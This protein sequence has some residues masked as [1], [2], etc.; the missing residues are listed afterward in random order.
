MPATLSEA[1]RARLRELRYFD[2]HMTAVAAIR[3]VGAQRW[4]DAHFLRRLEA[5]KEYLGL[6]R[7]DS[8]DGFVR[9]FDILLPAEGFAPVA[10]DDLFDAATQQKIRKVSR[11]IPADRLSAAEME[12]FGRHIV[13]DHPWFVELQQQLAPR[14]SALAGRE[15]ECGYNFLSLY[16]GGGKCDPHMDSPLAMYTL[17]YCIEQSEDWPIWFSKVC[18]W[19]SA[20]A[21]RSWDAQA[22][23]ADPALAFRAYRL[24]PGKALLFNGSSQWHYRDALAA[25][26]FCSLLFFHYFPKGAAKLV[27][28]VLWSQHFDIPELEPLCDLFREEFAEAG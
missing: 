5:A 2:L 24:Q 4:Y 10:I 6:V 3:K 12:D 15:L 1:I 11:T 8:L 17:D 9:A 19:P 14:I 13:H 18:D 7:P 20:E 21:I 28:P 27:R 23:K 16:R 22:I 26:G 25:N